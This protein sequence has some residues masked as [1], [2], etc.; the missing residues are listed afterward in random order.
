MNNKRSRRWREALL[1]AGETELI[2]SGLREL[3][4]YFGIS[5]SAARQACA[6][7]LYASKR[8]WEALPRTTPQAIEDFYRTT[9]SYLFE[10]VWWHATDPHENAVNVAL[11]DYARSLRAHTYLDFGAGVGANAILFAQHGFKVTLADLSPP[12][13]DFARWR[14]ERRQL[15]ADLI[16]LNRQSLPREQFE[17]ATAV[18][19]LEHLVD[20]ATALETLSAA[21]VAGGTLAFNFRA[22][23]DPLRPMHILATGAPIFRALRSCGLRT[24]HSGT[25]ELEAELQ[26]RGFHCVKRSAQSRVLNWCYGAFDAVYYSDRAQTWLRR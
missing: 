23:S 9:R 14:L 12:M 8:E 17:F 6:E 24:T 10:H 4:E 5:Q 25:S 16:D 20:P 7:A 13:L 26:A 11:L 2:E 22:G 1:L 18:D 15:K 19:V 3:A 21:L